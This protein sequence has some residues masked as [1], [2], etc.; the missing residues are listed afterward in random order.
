MIQA[1]HLPLH[2]MAWYIPCLS[3]CHRL[4]LWGM[5]LMRRPAPAI[6][7][8]SGG[9]KGSNARPMVR[10]VILD[11]FMLGHVCLNVASAATKSASEQAVSCAGCGSHCRSG[12]G[13]RA[14]C[15]RR[16]LVCALLSQRQ[17]FIRR[18]ET[19]RSKCYTS[20]VPRWFGLGGIGEPV[21]TG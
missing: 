5:I 4:A 8:V 6:W 18:Y 12:S 2:V 13:L 14:W 17:L 10:A 9:P 19:G 20:Y 1:F 15:R 16:R 11:V 21:L 3:G 7:S